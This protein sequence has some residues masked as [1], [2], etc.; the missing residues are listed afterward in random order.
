MLYVPTALYEIRG[1]NY[2]VFLTTRDWEVVQGR[3]GW[4]RQIRQLSTQI[5]CGQALPA[6]APLSSVASGGERR[7]VGYSNIRH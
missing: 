5:Q 6:L 4:C 2:L 3:G 1:F 7:G